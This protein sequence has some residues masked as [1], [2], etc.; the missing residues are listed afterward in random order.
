MDAL[1]SGDED[2]KVD[3]LFN[4][5]PVKI[6]KVFRK[7]GSW[8]KVKNSAESKV[9]DSLK[10]CQVIRRNIEKERVALIKFRSDDRMDQGFSR[11]RSEKLPD[12]TDILQDDEGRGNSL[13]DMKVKR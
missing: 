5:E 11:I 10:F 12:R 7:V 13:G 9:L 1:E 2:F 6:L 4:S 8:M 3:S